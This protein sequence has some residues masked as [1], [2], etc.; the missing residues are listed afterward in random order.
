MMSSD[1]KTEAI[2]H[3]KTVISMFECELMKEEDVNESSG[4]KKVDQ[5]LTNTD[6]FEGHIK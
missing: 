5:V 2:E 1:Y 4:E 6:Y 3:I